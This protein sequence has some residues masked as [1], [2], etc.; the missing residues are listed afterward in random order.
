[1]IDQTLST[2]DASACSG[3]QLEPGSPNSGQ[4]V[5]GVSDGLLARGRDLVLAAAACCPCGCESVEAI[6]GKLMHDTGA[7]RLVADMCDSQSQSG[8]R[9]AIATF[10]RSLQAI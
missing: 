6:A 5:A 2:A 7:R 8:D 3:N 10:L 4:V 1:M 9:D